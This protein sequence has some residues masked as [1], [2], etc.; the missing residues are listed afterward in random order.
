MTKFWI[1]CAGAAL[2]AAPALAESHAAMGDAEAGEEAFKNCQSCHVVQDDEGN[3]IAGRNGRSGPNLYG[4]VGRQAGVL[5]DFRYSR[6][7]QEAGEEGLVW[8]EE[9]L[10]AFMQD[11]TG[12]LREHTGDDRARSKMSYKLRDE[13]E[14]VNLA[15]FLAKVGP[16][17]E[18]E[19]LPKTEVEGAESDVTD[20]ES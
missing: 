19:D 11:P 16:E 9:S 15:A 4:V 3:T 10:A 14:A 5:E 2:L 6:D 7:L 20:S 13:E 17:R 8:D 1:T 18:V 12:Y